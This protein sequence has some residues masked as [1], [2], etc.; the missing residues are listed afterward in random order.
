[1]SRCS[2]DT[3]VFLLCSC[4]FHWFAASKYHKNH[5]FADNKV[6]IVVLTPDDVVKYMNLL[7]AFGTITPAPDA[8]PTKTRHATIAFDKKK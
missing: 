2:R 7:K 1:M 8:N 5:V 3:S 4:P 6:L